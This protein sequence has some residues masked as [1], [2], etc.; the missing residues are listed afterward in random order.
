MDERSAYMVA[1]TFRTG[2]LVTWHQVST[3]SREEECYLGVVVEEREVETGMMP[4]CMYSVYDT[5]GDL[6]VKWSFEMR[7]VIP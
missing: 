3:Q 7:V 5:N 2:S 6:W 4:R 1:R